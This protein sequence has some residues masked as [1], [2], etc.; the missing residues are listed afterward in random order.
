MLPASPLPKIA[1]EASRH[2]GGGAAHRGLGRHHRDRV[3]L[4]SRR[5]R[6]RRGRLPW[7]LSALQPWFLARRGL[8]LRLR[9]R[10]L[11]RRRLGAW[12]R[13][14]LAAPARRGL[15]LGS[16]GGASHQLLVGRVAIDDRFVFPS[17]RAR[18]QRR[19]PLALLHRADA[20][21]RRGDEAALDRDR[22]ALGVEERQQRLA[23]TQLLDRLDRLEFRVGPEGLGRHLHGFLVLGR[24]GA[25]RMLHAIAELAQHAVGNVERVLRHE[26]DADTLRADQPHHLLDALEQ[27]PGG[28]VEQEMRLVEEEDEARFV[29]VADLGQPLEQF[30]QQPQQER[31]V[32]TRA[33]H[34]PVGRQDVD[35]PGARRVDAHHIG[36]IERGFAEE[37]LAALLVEHQELALDGADTR[38]ADIAVLGGELA[39]VFR[40]P[41]QHR[42]KVLEVEQQQALLV[43]DLEDDVEHALLGLVEL[44]QAGH[45]HRPDLAHRG[46]DGMALLA[47]QVPVGDREGAAGIAIDRELLRPLDRAWIVAALLAD[48]CEITLHVGHEHRHAEGGETLGDGLQRHRLAGAGG[49]GNQP[50]PV[51]ELQQQVL[52]GVAC[53]HEDRLVVAQQSLPNDEP[54][55]A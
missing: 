27:R 42:L 15:R 25:Q 18:L 44:Q 19:R 53:A 12:H 31:G 22:H 45:Q 41:L 34:Q 2:D 23:D 30:G 28:I 16:A 9:P 11:R 13:A 51:A 14:I 35:H 40:H 10:T 6:R 39:G 54:T 29:E 26:V 21:L 38:L 50:V 46:A 43:G 32:E 48:A 7:S 36:E 33:L 49:A 3:A 17:D 24:E 52:I 55:L 8:G 5:A 1:F 37:S 20:A 4:T 47:E